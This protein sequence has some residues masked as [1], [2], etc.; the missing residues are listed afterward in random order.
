[1][2]RGG[3][4]PVRGPPAGSRHRPRTGGARR[5]WTVTASPKSG[6]SRSPMPICSGVAEVHR[7][8]VHRRESGCRSGW[9]GSHRRR[10]GTH[11]D[12]HVRRQKARRCSQGRLAAVHGHVDALAD[13]AHLE[14]GGDQRLLEGK[15]AAEGEGDEVVLP[16]RADVAAFLA[17]LG[18]R[19]TRGRPAGRCAGRY[20]RA[21]AV[22][23]RRAPG[24]RR[25]RAGTRVG[26]AEAQEIPPRP[27]A[28]SPGCTAR[29]RVR[30]RGVAREF[31]AA[32]ALRRAAAGTH[33]SS[34]D[35]GVVTAGVRSGRRPHR[36]L[37]VRLPIV[38][39]RP[40]FYSMRRSP[41][42]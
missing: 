13:V 26:L 6:A 1:M 30:A 16:Q 32:C 18:R 14:A 39:A 11:A 22:P 4:P 17:Q 37:R 8:A 31:A 35:W 27:R 19:G 40:V 42:A 10:E 36:C 23:W 38:P 2:A 15:G 24:C 21:R 20:R 5:R 7:C 41:K 34:P 28:G 33:G 3:P 25:E 29:S 12:D 9:R